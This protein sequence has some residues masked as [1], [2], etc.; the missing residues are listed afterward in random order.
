MTL[1]LQ[2]YKVPVW[3]LPALGYAI[4]IGSL[5]WVLQ[6]VDASTMWADLRGLHW[7][8][9]GLAVA[10]DI[11][12]YVIQGWRWNM[13]LS[14]V[15]RVPIW[16]SIQAVYVGL[17]ANEVL[18]LRPGEVI[19]SYLQARWSS[20][21]FSVTFSSAIIERIID[22]LWLMLAFFVTAAF[23]T[24]PGVIMDIA[25]LVAVVV[26]LFAVFLGL[27]MFRKG[28]AHAIGSKTRWGAHIKVLIED[29]HLM[30]NSR[31]FYGAAF[32][33][34]PYLLIQVVPVYG[35]MR[36]YGLDLSVWPA[37]VVLLILR[38]G[39]VVPQAPGNLGAAQAL[40]V[41]A[42][43]LFGV[44]K[45]TATGVSLM[46]WTVIT[47]PLLVAGAIALAFT[48]L[49]LGDLKDHANAHMAAAPIATAEAQN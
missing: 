44:D 27:V 6:D 42:L 48:G 46:T 34:L 36:A 23:V 39:T 2:K 40:I 31:S 5:V 3:F 28:H 4:S 43:G 22:G 7:G 9:V 47:M 45:T 10:G 19:R 25:K 26:V 11:L 30:G 41:L 12:T 18:P 14:P 35:L 24:L 38:I 8:W 15:V 21:P 13:L 29:L 16:R 33:S 49:K 32:A 17:F 1:G 37:M 20:L